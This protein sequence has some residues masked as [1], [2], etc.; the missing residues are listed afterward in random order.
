MG[1]QLDASAASKMSCFEAHYRRRF[2]HVAPEVRQVKV[3]ELTLMRSRQGAGD[4]SCPAVPE[5]ALV[6]QNGGRVDADAD[7]GAGRFQ[8][9]LIR[10]DTFV[11]APHV[12]TKVRFDRPHD[13]LLLAVDYAKLKLLCADLALPGDGYF[14]ALHRGPVRDPLVVG[15]IDCLWA[16]AEA[17]EPPRMLLRENALVCLAAALVARA[18]SKP[19]APT[20]KGQLA[21]WQERRAIERL[22]AELAGNVSLASLAADVGLS[23][24]HFARAFKRSTGLPPHRYQTVLRIERAKELLRDDWRSITTIALD[25][26]Y[27]SSQSLARAFTREVGMSP[28]AYRRRAIGA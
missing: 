10:G 18:D 6:K 5:L 16:E 22:T 15:L 11:A 28:L 25:L 9:R 20:I 17:D 14:A 1:T 23:P 27:G 26:G 2:D 8:H 21:P 12:A 19:A 3:P 24:F 7:L 13:V 4:W